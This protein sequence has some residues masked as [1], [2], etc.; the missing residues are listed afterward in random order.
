M[1]DVP[2]ETLMAFVD[3]ELSPAEQKHIEAILAR[4]PD[5]RAR[6]AAFEATGRGLSAKF[7]SALNEPVPRH[8]VDLLVGHG[9][10]DDGPQALRGCQPAGTIRS[11][12]LWNKVMR[13][14]SLGV[15]LWPAALAYAAVLLVGV[16]AGSYLGHH[17]PGDAPRDVARQ[18]PVLAPDPLIVLDNGNLVASGRLAQVLETMPGAVA[19]ALADSDGARPSAT[20]RIRLTFESQGGYCRQ[21]EVV[22]TTGESTAEVACRSAQ[23]HWRVVAH[24]AAGIGKANEFSTNPAAAAGAKIEA[25]VEQL[26]VGDAFGAENEAAAIARRWQR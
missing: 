24:A 17:R 15:P 18:A 26:L 1:S 6:L 8:L 19:H 11:R 21:Y 25:V 7:S 4:S 10:G 9:R 12:R 3:G 20:V 2:D 16:G 5:L 13:A 14:P 23:G 22:G